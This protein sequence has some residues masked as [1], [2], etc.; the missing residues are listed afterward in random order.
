MEGGEM[1]F[2]DYALLN[3]GSRIKVGVLGNGQ[4]LIPQL[5]CVCVWRGEKTY[6]TAMTWVVL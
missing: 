2:G 6:D 5:V 1:S 4:I 3:V